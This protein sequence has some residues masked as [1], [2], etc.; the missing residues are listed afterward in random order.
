LIILSTF[1][2]EMVDPMYI[3]FIVD[4]FLI[5]LSAIQKLGAG[6]LS[7]ATGIGANILVVH[8]LE[9]SVVSGAPNH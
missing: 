6:A 3:E 7:A 4:D 1:G 8:V 9:E 5:S 2:L